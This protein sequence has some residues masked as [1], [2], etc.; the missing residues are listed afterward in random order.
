M[1]AGPK[2]VHGHRG[3]IVA[4]LWV[5]GVVAALAIGMLVGAHARPRTTWITPEDDF[6]NWVSVEFERARRYEQPLA[7]IRF[8]PGKQQDVSEVLVT[9]MQEHL[10]PTDHCRCEGDSIYL[11][12]PETDDVGAQGLVRRVFPAEVRA[13]GT[14]RVASYPAD[15]ITERGLLAR[16]QGKPDDGVMSV[17]GQLQEAP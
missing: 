16:L 10:R 8:E 3:Q 11:L 12:A 5:L 7:F 9:A 14:V 15:S 6:W 17:P 4:A 2:G 13:A 1:I